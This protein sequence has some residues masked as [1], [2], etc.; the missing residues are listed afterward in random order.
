M[1]DIETQATHQDLAT[2]RDNLRLLL[3]VTSAIVTKLDLA[4]L[5]DAVSSS[6]E[7]A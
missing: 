1:P 6:L 3:D 5:V 7:R 2:E 4:E